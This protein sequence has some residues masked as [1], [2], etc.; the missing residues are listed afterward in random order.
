MGGAGS[1]SGS[2]NGANGGTGTGGG[3]ATG[4]G[5][6]MGCGKATFPITTSKTAP[7]VM[8]VV[9]ESGSMTET[10][11]GTT[12]T[13]WDS[14]K[15]SLKALLAQYVGEVN[16]G[17]SVFPKPG[18]ADQCTP[19]AVD[20]PVGPNNTQK[21][22]AVLQPL[23]D[24]TIGGSTP[25]DQTIQAVMAGGGLNDTTRNNYILLM[26]DGLPNCGSDGTGV[27]KTI[28]SAYAA[29]PS[30]STFVVG[31]GAD[32]QSSPQTLDSWATAGHSARKTSPL[33]Y[34]ANNVNDLNMAFGEI[35][36]GIASCTYKLTD[37][38]DDPSLLTVYIDGHLVPIDATNGVTYDPGSQS[39]V[40]HGMSC[41]TVKAGAAKV[42][43]IYGCPSPTIG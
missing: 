42:D 10:V 31:I 15:D 6:I 24:Q 12:S 25:T 23:T 32:T 5:E 20:V 16:W 28:A 2:G 40:L 43:V 38:P 11:P 30:V 18:A 26:T 3:D 27:E 17:L 13:K 9:D 37:K 39:I 33:Y 19:G 7:N 22:L 14:L 35:V 4:S 1:G 36:A 34:Q 8:L 29:T 41:D 21:V